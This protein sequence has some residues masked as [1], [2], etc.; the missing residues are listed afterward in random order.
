SFVAAGNTPCGVAV[1]S[2]HLY[3]AH[4]IVPSSDTA[5]DAIGRVNLDG[6]GADPSF[7]TGAFN[8]W[9][10]A[11]DASTA[12]TAQVVNGALEFRATSAPVANSV[13]LTGPASGFYTLHDNGARITPG[14]GC[15]AVNG[16]EVRC[17]ATSITGSWLDSGAGND[18]VTVSTAIPTT[19]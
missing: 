8:P 18:T 1:D 19:I 4:A 16:H 10:G 6:T 7:I 12:G 5:D 2:A 14:A 17:A 13:T 3:W 15:M 9:G 11:V